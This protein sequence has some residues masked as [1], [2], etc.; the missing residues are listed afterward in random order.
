[1]QYTIDL[2]RLDELRAALAAA[3]QLVREELGAAV[4]EADGLLYREVV[5]RMPVG[6]GGAS[7]LKGSVFHEEEIGDTGV[8][9]LVATPL[10]YAVPVE[11]GTKPHFVPIEPLIDWVQAKM[12]VR[13]ET[14]ARGIAFAISKTIAVRGTKP[15]RPFGLTFQEKYSDVTAIFDRAVAR[16]AARLGEAR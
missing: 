16:I 8:T 12:H 10:S 5:E 7:G 9:G 6:A 4:T 2:S 14:T 13:D 15:R 1:M 11:L 3:P